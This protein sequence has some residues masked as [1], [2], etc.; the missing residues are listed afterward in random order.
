MNKFSR[1]CLLVTGSVFFVFG[2]SQTALAQ[3]PTTAT[4]S[5]PSS[6]I[7]IVPKECQDAGGCDICDITRVFV[8]AANLIA[9][10]LGGLALLMFVAGGLMLIF[11]AGVETRVETGKKIL[12]GTV[13]G[14]A[15]V[16]IA[17]LAVNIIVRAAALSGGTSTTKVFSNNWWDLGACNPPAPAQCMTHNISD[18][19]S[20]GTCKN[21]KDPTCYCW[22]A[23]TTADVKCSGEDTTDMS[24][25][26]DS[27]KNTK[28]QC[29]CIDGCQQFVLEGHTGYDCVDATTVKS[30]TKYDFNTTVTCAKPDTICA[31]LK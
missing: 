16:F 2:L 4:T 26:K 30:N 31:K 5:S 23:N 22:R 21:I 11:S 3:V 29:A 1:F 9:S 17:W 13:T 12:I 10:I 25:I 27:T 8:N 6:W 20:I 24:L 19:C 18:K 15:I 14:L 7:N 28:N